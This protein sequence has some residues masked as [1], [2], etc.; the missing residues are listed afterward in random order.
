MPYFSYSGYDAKGKSTK[1]TIEAG[2]S[3][4][5]VDRLTERGIVVVDVKLAED[6]KG[7]A[8]IKL[9]PLEQHIFFC[10]SLASYLK[11]GLPLADS[12][13]IMSKQ[14][15]DKTMKPVM[16]KILAEVEG[17][18]KFHTALAESGAFRESLWRV[19]ESGEQSGTLIS[20]LN[21][22]ADEFKLEDDLHRKIRGAMTYPIVMAV[23]GVGVVAFMLTYVVPKISELFED[24][25]QTLP[26]PT[27]ILIGMSDFLS[28]F[29]LWILLAF[30]ILYLW[31]KKTGRS[32]NLP[33]M[34][35][36]RDQLTLALVMSHLSTLL[37]SG[38]PLVQA[39]RMA[40]SMDTQ[41]QRWID[42]AEM[43]KAGHRFDKALE[44]IGMPE[45]TVAVVRVGEMGGELAE[46]LTNV[47]DQSRE[48]AQ[49]RMERLSTLME[50][51][52]VLSLGVSVGFIV[53]AILTPVFDLAG[54]VR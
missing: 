11:S 53:L 6:K 8:K 21:E 38:I 19:A 34:R 17:G 1:G 33:F 4:Q 26:L 25:H 27:R 5:A 47:S 42:A 29:G 50:P 37:K 16:E 46:A 54:I 22:A 49:T 28:N 32:F 35:G 10:R 14:A 44:K 31:M 24:M 48:I 45:E 23:V 15:R 30:L 40:S 52:M 41:K 43:V 18:R 7:P 13:R 39:L 36:I 51:I 20:V 2:S 3:M 9:L 12:I